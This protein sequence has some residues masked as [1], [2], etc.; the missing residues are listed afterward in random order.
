MKYL[1]AI[2]LLI[3]IAYA[4]P[5]EDRVLEVPD[6]AKFDTFELYS[7]YLEIPDKQRRLHY[8]LA[9][10][11]NDPKNDP[12]VI[13]FNGGP[14]CS[15]M[16]GFAQ[17]HGP[18]VMPDGFTTFQKNPESWNLEANVLYIES[19]AGVGY[20]YYWG[21]DTD[22]FDDLTSSE[23]NYA[24]LLVF[25]EKFPEYKVNE[26][27]ISG[28]SY[29]GIYVP[30]LAWQ[31][32]QHNDT[33]NLQGII[34]GNGV[35]NY[36]YDTS[37]AYVG[38]GFW[39]ALY[40][41]SIHD[42]IEEL[43]CSFANLDQENPAC[44]QLRRDFY[45]LVSKVNVYDVYRHCWYPN[46]TERVGSAMIKGE[47]KT[48]KK[49]MTA[50][51]YTPFLFRNNEDILEEDV[52]C[53]YAKGTSEFF[54]REDVRDAFNVET[55]QVWELCTDRI[56]YNSEEKASYWIYP[57]LKESNIRVMHFSGNA[58]GSVPT[59][60]TRDWI[61][62]LNWDKVKPYSPFYIENKQ[63]GGFVEQYDGIILASIQGIGHMAAQWSP[64]ATRYAVMQ[65]IKNQPIDNVEQHFPT[66]Q[67][68]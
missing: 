52:P 66:E 6:M 19:P 48:Y 34:V 59:Q 4:K 30:Y 65:F 43:G 55:D 50:K 51:Q 10:S 26:L 40:D 36:T 12:L 56:D 21:R 37:P 41:T 63:V 18:Y 68:S 2:I 33:I 45:K 11:Q 42:K 17:E 24:A 47:L 25:F 14:G 53:V 28:E 38:M 67:T 22:S 54:N 13:W 29:A 20:S 62:S 49:G 60:G 5:T 15:S 31:I 46:E 57:I 44:A 32:L 39:H 8:V 1:L 7:G 23:D 61:D 27:F 64:T 58:D 35:T 9:E 16:L 3:A